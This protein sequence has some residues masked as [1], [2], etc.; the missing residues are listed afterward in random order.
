VQLDESAIVEIE[1]LLSIPL[2]SLALKVLDLD[3]YSELLTY[4]PWENRRQVATILVRSTLHSNVQLNSIEKIEK[5]FATITPLLKDEEKDNN[6]TPPSKDEEAT[7]SSSNSI[8]V[9]EQT[10]VARLVHQMK[11]DDNDLQ[12]KIFSMARKQ[13][14]QGGVKRIKHTL[15]PLVFSGL[16]LAQKVKGKELSD[17][18]MKDKIAKA[19]QKQEEIMAEWREKCTAVGTDEDGNPNPKPPKPSAVKIPD[20]P[21][22]AS[23]SCRKVFQFLHEIV[24]AMA[25]TFP[26]MSLRLYLQS[27]ITADNCRFKAISYEFMS[28]AFIIYEDELTDSKAQ[29]RALIMMV[30]T[31]LSCKNFDDNDY[32][33][34]I[35]KTTQYAAKMLKKP[36][37]CRMVTL[38]SHL[39]FSGD[40]S[41]ANHYHDPRR[42]LECLQRALKIADACMASSHHV[43]LFVEIL[44]HYLYYFERDCSSVTH[45]YLSG[46]IA[47]IN[48]HIGNLDESSDTKV[49][50]ETIYKATIA[51]IQKKKETVGGKY[52][53]IDV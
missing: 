24:T 1:E 20:P 27:A 51:H 41:E 3:Q 12:F 29:L 11:S 25:T 8:F 28:Q 42:V 13:F 38:C 46:L 30:G 40:E 22:P 50:V 15:V 26:D 10:L 9:E 47:L 43:L 7:N 39:F 16:A 37:Q 18:K 48:E 44:G 21:V 4:L 6:D 52:E 35:T 32:D 14:G 23:I 53:A 31:L 33:A 45:K 49:E 36:D 19:T 5:L 2:S 17:A 34:L